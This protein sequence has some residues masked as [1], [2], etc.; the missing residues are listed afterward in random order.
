MNASPDRIMQKRNLNRSIFYVDIKM[1]NTK[2]KCQTCGRKIPTSG[3]RLSSIGFRRKVNGITTLDDLINSKE[4]L[5]QFVKSRFILKE[6]VDK[7]LARLKE[8]IDCIDPENPDNDIPNIKT[9]IL[10]YYDDTDPERKGFLLDK[11]PESPLYEFLRTEYPEINEPF[12]EFYEYYAHN[13]DN[14]LN[15]N[16]VSRALTALGLKT[17]MKKIKQNQDGGKLKC[18]M[19]LSATKDELSEIFRKN[20]VTY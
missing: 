5:A 12:Q 11:D 3:S 15:K 18:T 13:V 4:Y 8:E 7:F 1:S 9:W 20:G 2:P 19:M 6:Y 16:Y 10:K 14:P 17:A